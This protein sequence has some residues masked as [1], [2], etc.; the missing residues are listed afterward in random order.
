MT[1]LIEIISVLGGCCAN[2]VV[3]W[4]HIFTLDSSDVTL[5]CVHGQ[6]TPL[7]RA[8]DF[9]YP[10]YSVSRRQSVDVFLHVR[11]LYHDNFEFLLRHTEYTISSAGLYFRSSARR[12]PWKECRQVC[13]AHLVSFMRTVSLSIFVL[14][15]HFA[16]ELSWLFLVANFNRKGPLRYH[17]IPMR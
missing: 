13:L 5:L 2:F 9:F 17:V 14:R 10:S 15:Y 6:H 1:P 16:S 11:L 8:L 7:V 3:N 12:I 4:R